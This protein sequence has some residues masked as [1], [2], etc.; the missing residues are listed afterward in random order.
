MASKSTVVDEP[1]AFAAREWLRALIV[2]KPVRFVTK[3]QQPDRVYGVLFA[4]E[5]GTNLALE[6]V[7]QGHAIPK[8]I[9]YGTTTN[10]NNNNSTTTTNDAEQTDVDEYEQQ[11]LTAHTEA[12]NGNRGLHGP[13]PL[14]RTVQQCGEEFTALALVEACQKHAS[15]QRISCVIEHVFDGTRM[16]CQVVDDQLP[17][18]QYGNFTLLLA[19][20]TSPRMGNPNLDPPIPTELL[21]PQARQFVVARVLQRQLQISLIGTDK[22][23]VALVGIVHHPA[24]NIAIELLKHGL[25]RVTDWSVRLLAP[26]E[27]PAL[28]VAE[29]A[30]KRASLGVW[31]NYAPPVLQS[32]SRVTGT[33]LEVVTGDT[34]SILPDGKPAEEASLWKV[35]LASVRAPRPG[36]QNRPEE[37]YAYEC[38][39]K[40]RTMTIGKAVTVDVH[41]EREIPLRPGVT[42]QRPFGTV[43]VVGAK[44]TDIAQVLI[45]D[46]LAQTQ[47]HRDEDE[48]SPRYDDLRAA[49]AVAKAAKKGVHKQTPYKAPTFNDLTEPRKAKAYHGS[50]MRAGKIKAVVEYVFNGALFKLYVPAENCHI[51]FSLANVRCPQPSPSPGS[52]QPGKPAEP[53]GDAAK[54][55]AKLHVLQRNVEIQCGGVTNSGI[56]TGTLTVQRRD[57]TLELLG[58]GYCTVDARKIE[59][60]EAPKNLVDAQATAQ[61]NKVGIWSIAPV[62]KEV[63]VDNRADEKFGEAVVQGQLSEIRSGH[64]FFYHV[65]NDEALSVMDESMKLFTKTNGTAGGPCDTKLH[66]VVAALFDDGTGKRWYRAKIVERKGPSKVSVLFIDYG[67]LATVPVS[68]HL[69]PLDMTLGADRIP[70]IAKEAVL[71]FTQTRGIDTEEG[72]SAARLLQELCW[73]K[74]LMLRTL[75]PNPENGKMAVNLSVVADATDDSVNAQLIEAGVARV[76]KTADPIASRMADPAPAVDLFSTLRTAEQV[77]RKSRA[78]MWRY[79]DVGDEDPDEI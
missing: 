51:R 61:S 72:V 60:G 46:G 54:L 9:K 23:G 35:S 18:F 65:L 33:V 12:S 36:N 20:V 67:N 17:Q 50:L 8:S 2:G 4:A 55:H 15:Q 40:L 10:N 3:K 31:Q 24:G 62:K 68:T 69:R 44:A 22:N 42:E 53:F 48:K 37:P 43:A 29:N 71:A 76:T 78:G 73:G 74:D 7:R 28:R 13:S 25:A 1:G 59:Y 79:G 75:A 27:V 52:R 34:L 70:P 47:R 30:A 56:I 32:A 64:H 45:T 66:S 14:V 26:P 58:A 77:A 16:R 21:A 38:K 63:A 49:E 57:Y 41:Y 19:G 11:L 39:D 5:T 6:A